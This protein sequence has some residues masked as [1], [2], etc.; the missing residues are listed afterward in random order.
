MHPLVLAL[1]LA[2]G[3][4][5][6][7]PNGPPSATSKERAVHDGNP[8]HKADNFQNKEADKSP[9]G[10]PHRGPEGQPIA[11]AHEGDSHKESCDLLYRCYLLA[12]IFGVCGGFIGL[13]FIWRQVRATEIS[14][15][16][17]SK[18][19][20]ALMDAER[21]WITVSVRGCDDAPERFRTA[22]NVVI[23]NVGKI[24]ARI[25]K[26]AVESRIVRSIQDMGASTEAIDADI[27]V[28]N[29]LIA[30]SDPLEVTVDI[31]ETT[32]RVAVW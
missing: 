14:A 9:S 25:K 3:A 8:Q 23:R 17:A 31:P 7:Q 29:T 22:A 10:V 27:G 32:D 28:A 24:P 1:F 6:A 2:L 5:Q 19:A 13:Y 18:N 21:A 11:E 20:V 15:N 16:A 12:T 30:P 4:W 26:F